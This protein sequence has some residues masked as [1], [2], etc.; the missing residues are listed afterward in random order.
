MISAFKGLS[1]LE[2]PVGV[3]TCRDVENIALL[4]R[5]GDNEWR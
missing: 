3:T 2:L 1:W 4:R 5:R